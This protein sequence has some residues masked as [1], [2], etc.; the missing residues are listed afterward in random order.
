MR[1]LLLYFSRTIRD[2]YD[3]GGPTVRNRAETQIASSTSGLSWKTIRVSIVF[4]NLF[5]IFITS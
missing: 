2:A 1:S 4:I 3:P 5:G